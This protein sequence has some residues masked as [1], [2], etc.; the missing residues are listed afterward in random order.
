M[1]RRQKKKAFKKKY[2]FNQPRYASVI[3]FEKRAEIIAKAAVMAAKALRE[4]CAQVFT[5]AKETIEQIQ[6]MPEEEF[7]KVLETSEVDEGTKEMARK[8]R[9][10]STIKR[11]NGKEWET[12]WSR[13]G[14]AE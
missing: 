6:T 2:G 4:R 11:H 1:N 10:A 14:E 8:L 5:L 3:W 9:V 13:E 7:I 12:I